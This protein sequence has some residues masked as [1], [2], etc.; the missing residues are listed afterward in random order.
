M[1]ILKLQEE[2]LKGPNFVNYKM[3]S[4]YHNPIFESQLKGKSTIFILWH[5]SAEPDKGHMREIQVFRQLFFRIAL[6][7]SY[8]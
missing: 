2:D 7:L 1:W 8:G 3:P 6:Y 5:L 4:S